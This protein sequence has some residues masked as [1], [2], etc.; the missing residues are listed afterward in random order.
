MDDRSGFQITWH[1]IVTNMRKFCMD[2]GMNKY[3][4]NGDHTYGNEW[5]IN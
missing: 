1:N 2:I 5:E 3:I 4:K